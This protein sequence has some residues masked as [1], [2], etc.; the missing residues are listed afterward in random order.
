MKK[1]YWNC[2][3]CPAVF[4]R[5]SVASFFVVLFHFSVC[6]QTTN[7]SGII[8]TYHRVVEI[9]PSK[10][11]VR[12]ANI[13]GLNVNSR[14][15]LLQMKGASVITTN[16]STFGDTTTLNGAGNYEIGTVCYIIGDSVF[17]F[18]NLLN[19]YN[20]S[21]GKVQ[22]VQF[23]EYQ[24]ANVVDTVKAAS[25]DSVASTG[26]VIAI[27][28]YQDITLNAPIYAD[29][30]GYKGGSFIQSN[31]TC[32]NVLPANGYIYNASVITPQ[33][34]AYK[35]ESAA[36]LTIAQS[37][38]RGAPAN[39][40]GGGNNHNNSGGGGSNLKS[41]GKGGGNSSSTGCSTSLQ[42]E[43]GKALSSWNG[44]KIFMGGG[45]GAGHSNNG[46]TV[47]RGGNGGGIIFIWA[48]NLIGN[49]YSIRTNGGNGGASQSD[50][51]GGGGGGGSIVL[52][53]T[54]YTGNTI[55]W[56]TGGNGGN[57]D[58]GLNIGRCYGGGGG[59]SG[60]AVYFSGATPAVTVSISGGVAGVEVNRDPGCNAAVPAT[61]GSTGQIIPNY[62]FPRSTDPAGYCLLLL[63]A[64]LLY[65]H[66][67]LI[68]QSVLLNWQLDHPEL[69]MRFTVEKKTEASGWTSLASLDASDTRL[70]YSLTDPNPG[71]GNNFY[72]LKVTEK[73]NSDYY[74]E[75]RKIG[76]DLYN[77]DFIIY[78][79]PASDKIII[80]GKNE[81][82]M[83][84]R[85]TDISG[86]TVWKQKILNNPAE[87]ALPRL[88]A[89][90][91]L[92]QYNGITKKLVIR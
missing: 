82:G 15:M 85:I 69:V 68:N 54:T 10:G 7:I 31:N 24:S 33:N 5:I 55:L 70:N 74:S 22:L 18:H 56:T 63:P 64:K 78:P 43:A 83:W 87:I 29:S 72:R 30:S 37:G 13:T 67:Q 25:W 50:G 42:G 9:I 88:S 77:H 76:V 35:G 40:G 6:A 20:T 79:N 57:S 92:V 71:Y 45:G 23:A 39:G 17:L 11:C 14:I 61:A 27:F 65:F 28:A 8:N 34:G 26:G 53:V 1:I 38:G 59:G 36:T 12:V 16:T 66:V 89:G 60:G 91:Y 80:R 73:S 81:T 47:V 41:G 51:A 46:L 32:S 86:K 52:N 75:T 21:T 62:V 48:D 3:P 2:N 19:T 90:L 84:F 58:D 49:N 4:K 44:Q